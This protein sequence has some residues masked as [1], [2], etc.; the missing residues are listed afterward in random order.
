MSYKEIAEDIKNN[1]LKKM[2][3]FHGEES[4]LI[5]HYIN[6][7]KNKF[8]SKDFEDLNYIKMD[9]KEFTVDKLI[10]SLETL[11]FMSEKK[12]VV[13]KNS[14]LFGTKKK[15]LSEDEEDKLIKYL[16]NLP[17]TAC[18]I[19][20]TFDAIDARKKISKEIKK[21]GTVI[22]FDKLQLVELKKWIEKILRS[23][24]KE[25]N[26][27]DITYFINNLNYFDKSGNQ[28]LYNIENEIRKLIAFVGDKDVIHEGDINLVFVS[29]S[30]NNIFK[31]LDEIEKNNVKKAINILNE[32]INEG[33]PIIKILVVLS[34]HIRNLFKTK[35]LLVQGYSSKM[36]AQEL[37][38]HPFVAGKLVDQSRR[39]DERR[40]RKL[41]DICLEFDAKIKLSKIKQQIATELLIIEM[42]KNNK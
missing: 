42:C 39:F 26:Q 9:E 19:F 18:L 22:S 24:K 6:E 20:V 36:I 32:L 10:N 1:N 16:N 41:I 4:Y 15:M 27:S 11:P 8:I 31:L 38:I 17:D 23:H 14:E 35:L 28:D 34:N 40:L 30:Q 33:E 21:N 29:T 25:M 37:K 12:I 7:I 3:L 2:Y 13:V 5:N